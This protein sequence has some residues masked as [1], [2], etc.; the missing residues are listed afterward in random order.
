MTDTLYMILILVGSLVVV[1]G[2]GIGL[3]HVMYNEKVTGLVNKLNRYRAS[4]SQLD[5]YL[6]QH[7][8]MI[9]KEPEGK[10]YYATLLT[11]PPEEAGTKYI[12]V[13]DTILGAMKNAEKRF[14]ESGDSTWERQHGTHPSAWDHLHKFLEP[15]KSR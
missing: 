1:T 10:N 9:N 8:W 3:I 5:E 4:V 13:D 12:G 7:T 15:G 11:G 2:L 14:I 6:A